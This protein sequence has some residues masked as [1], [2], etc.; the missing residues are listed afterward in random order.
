MLWGQPIV[1]RQDRAFGDGSKDRAPCIAGFKVANHAAAHMIIDQQWHRGIL[2]GWLVQAHRNFV[3]VGPG[4]G[5]ILRRHARLQRSFQHGELLFHSRLH[6]FRF[7]GRHRR[8]VAAIPC[9]QLQLRL[10]DAAP[11]FDPLAAGHAHQQAVRQFEDEFGDYLLQAHGRLPSC[12]VD[13]KFSLASA[14]APRG[15]S[16]YFAAISRTPASSKAVAN[17]VAPSTSTGRRSNMC[18]PI[19][20][21]IPMAAAVR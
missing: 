10:E 12:L 7:Q 19:S 18:S 11:H 2:A 15:V 8:C 9:N 3:T 16:P 21:A 4:N 14:S 17:S 20:R 1:D 5:K 13:K 6:D